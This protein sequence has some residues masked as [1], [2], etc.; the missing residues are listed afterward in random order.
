MVAH[1][2][3]PGAARAQRHR[4]REGRDRRSRPGGARRSRS[5]TALGTDELATSTVVAPDTAERTPSATEIRADEINGY[6]VDPAGRARR[7]ARSSTAATTRATRRSQIVLQRR[8]AERRAPASAR[9]AR[10]PHRGA[11]RRDRSRRSTS[12]REHTTGEE[13]GHVGDRARSSSRYILAFILYMVIT[14]Y[15]VGVMRSVVQEKTSRVMELLVAAIK[16]RALMAG[17]ILGVG[18]AGLIQIARLAR[19]RRARARLPRRAARRCSASPAA[20]PALPPLALGEIAVVL[21]LLRARLLLL[22]GDV[23]RGRRDGLVGAGHAAGP[24]A[25]DDAA[26]HRR[27]V[28]AG[29]HATIRAA[30]RRRR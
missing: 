22:L 13:R 24:D 14:L 18:A 27:D 2:R 9:R 29:G 17:K 12:S 8:I 5:P 30:R 7:T 1:D 21:A 15:G 28:P 25:G 11:A 26:R 16:P 4:G 10:R 19:D 20:A 6:V 3:D 23:R